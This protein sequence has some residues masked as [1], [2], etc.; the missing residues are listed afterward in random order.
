[1]SIRLV[2][3]SPSLTCR[4]PNI[5]ASTPTQ[6]RGVFV[7][8]QDRLLDVMDRGEE[9]RSSTSRMSCGGGRGVSQ[10][11]QSAGENDYVR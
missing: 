2:A 1:M 10:S 3:F 8:H 7:Q 4:S 11:N 6:L 9:Q 5:R